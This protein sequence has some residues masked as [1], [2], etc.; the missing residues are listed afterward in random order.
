M[1]IDSMP[2]VSPV[3]PSGMP[4]GVPDLQA[5][6]RLTRAEFERRYEAMPENVKAELIEGVVYIMSSPVS[7]GNHGSPHAKVMTWMGVYASQTAGTDAGDNSTVR[8]DED[9]EPQPDGLLRIVDACGG[10]SRIVEKGYLEGSAELMAEISSS[11]ASYDLHDKRNAYRR[12]KVLEYLVWRVRDRA[13]DWFVWREGRYERL[14][15][16]ANG[17]YKSEVFPGLWLDP[18]ALLAGDM[19]RV[20]QV[21]QQGLASPE[22]SA[23][24]S[25]LEAARGQSKQV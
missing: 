21:L 15:P 22:H 5:G 13:I 6:D 16:D 2:H 19:G 14:A 24:V 12:N 25:K 8:L 11:S 7:F 3:S 1:S 4:V 17:W 18:A 9:N 10:Q 23:F 20:L